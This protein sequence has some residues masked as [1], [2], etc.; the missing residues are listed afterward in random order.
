MYTFHSPNGTQIA[1]LNA[2]RQLLRNLALETHYRP[3]EQTVD[4]NDSNHNSGPF[5]LLARGIAISLQH[6]DTRDGIV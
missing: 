6:R 2:C 1:C 4:H 3:T 5:A